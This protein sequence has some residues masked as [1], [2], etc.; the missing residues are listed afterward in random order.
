MQAPTEVLLV[1]D[2]PADSDLTTE[3][4]TR[5]GCR[6]HVQSVTDGVEAVAFLHREGKYDNVRLPD[7]VIL[8]LNLPR[9]DGRDVLSEVKSDPILR[10]TPIVIFST[11]QARHDIVRCYE[12]GANGYI[13]KPGNLQ[14]FIAA[15]TSIRDFWLI[16]ACLPRKGQQ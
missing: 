2:N 16:F 8:D 13:N 4:L 6:V 7:L 14:G 9:K 3:V 12:L 10:T 11:S 15:V 5:N 1:D